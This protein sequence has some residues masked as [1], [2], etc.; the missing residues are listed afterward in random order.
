VTLVIYGA[1][2]AAA[3]I[4]LPAAAGA[5]STLAKETRVFGPGR[6]AGG[7]LPPAAGWR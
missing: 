2:R 4:P 3:A 1:H 6:L 7:P 5:D